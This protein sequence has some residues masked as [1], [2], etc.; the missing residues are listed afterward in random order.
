M[1][2][3]TARSDVAEV[4]RAVA[5]AAPN[6]LDALYVVSALSLGGS[7]RK[8][9]RL[10]NSLAT[11]GMRIGVASLNGPETLAP[12]LNPDVEYWRLER[13]GKFSPGAVRRLIEVMK[14]RRPGIVFSV[15]LY[16]ALYVS[17]AAALLMGRA[18]A[19]ASLVNTTDFH[20]KRRRR[21][22]LYKRLLNYFDVIVY[23]C[24]AQRAAWARDGLLQDERVDVVYNGVDLQE[25][26]PHSL[27]E[28]ADALRRR[29]GYGQ[30]AFIIG[31]VGRL[32]P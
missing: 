4:Q 12:M 27:T 24:A 6:R 25:F 5:V 2:A 28:G 15:N 16:P 23:G 19:L 10:A 20:P 17:S 26:N 14:S 21:H 18:P 3:V 13:R 9:V 31:A 7:E 32:A 30:G 11:R 22:R 8:I 1:S 29:H